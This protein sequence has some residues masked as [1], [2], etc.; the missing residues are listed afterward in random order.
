MTHPLGA[1]APLATGILVLVTL[2]AV[3]P[4]DQASQRA[5]SRSWTRVKRGK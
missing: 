1:L 3:S 5:L 2:F 4:Y